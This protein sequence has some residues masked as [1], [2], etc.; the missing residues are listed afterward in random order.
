MQ[1]L[2]ESLPRLTAL[3]AELSCLSREQ[4]CYADAYTPSVRALI[5]PDASLRDALPH[6]ELLFVRDKIIPPSEGPGSMAAQMLATDAEDP[7]VATGLQRKDVL[8]ASPLKK[9]AS[10]TG[11]S[12]QNARE[13]RNDSDGAREANSKENFAGARR[14]EWLLSSASSL[15]KEFD[16]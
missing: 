15:I 4:L 12:V 14:V 5:N 7:E 8:Q 16:M 3:S 13:P 9:S 2:R 11:R 1:S 6:E 10:S